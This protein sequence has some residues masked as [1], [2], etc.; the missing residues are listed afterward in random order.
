[1]SWLFIPLASKS[2]FTSS[3]NSSLP[4]TPPR[5]TF[6]PKSIR[7]LATLAAPPIILDS[8]FAF[9]IGTGASGDSLVAEPNR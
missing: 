3:A 7:L 2:S 5:Y 9:T 6:A 8:L 4:T 1:M